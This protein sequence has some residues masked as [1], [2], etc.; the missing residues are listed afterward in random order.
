AQRGRCAAWLLPRGGFAVLRRSP[1]SLEPGGGWK[2]Q[3]QTSTGSSEQPWLKFPRATRRRARRSSCSA[4]PSATRWKPEASTRQAPTY[5][6][7]SDARRDKRQ[8]SATQ[9]PTRAKVGP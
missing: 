7:S 2:S 8:A 3:A 6:G 4:V 9:T 1:S 5:T